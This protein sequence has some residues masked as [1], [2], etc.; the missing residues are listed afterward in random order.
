MN[1]VTALSNK[2][3][4]VAGN[5]ASDGIIVAALYKFISLPDYRELRGPLLDLCRA[6]HIKGTLLLAQEGINGTVA[7]DRSGIDAL[8]NYLRCDRRFADLE[9]REAVAHDMPFYRMKVKLKK[10]IVTLGIPEIDPTRNSGIR[11][12]PQRWNELINDPEVL[13][14]DTRNRYEYRIGSFRNAVS[15]ETDSFSEFP[16]YVQQKLDP[17]RHKKIAMFCTGGIRCEKASAYLLEQG[18]AE[19][20]QLQGGILKYL[21]AISPDENQWLGECFVFDGRVAVNEK[22]DQGV[23]QQCYSCRMPVSPQDLESDKFE[24]GVSC[25]HC[26]DGQTEERRARLRERQHQVELA[27]QRNYQH[28]GAVLHT[29]E[30]PV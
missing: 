29:S 7:A 3:F 2:E 19:V 14:I 25:P 10:E 27:R 11:V 21:E 30:K 16:R 15:P 26:Y 20:Y 1:P 4:R 8:L 22:L 6:H 12:T 17:E 28:I 24:Q 13:V 18:F 9:H 5:P 23:Y